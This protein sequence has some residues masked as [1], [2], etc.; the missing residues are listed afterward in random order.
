MLFLYFLVSRS[1]MPVSYHQELEVAIRSVRVAAHVCRAVQ[2][3]MVTPQSLEK[4]D[5][6]PVTVADFASQAIVC[7]LLGDVLP[8]DPVVGE[9][10]AAALRQDEQVHVRDAVAQHVCEVLGDD[11]LDTN[12]VLSWIDRGNADGSTGRYWTL[13]PIDGT[14][15]FLRKEQY[16]I[17]L[18]L[19]EHHEVVLGVLGCPNLSV[20]DQKGALYWAHEGVGAHAAPLWEGT[21]VPS[22][23]TVSDSTDTSS[24]RFCESV[25]SAHSDQSQS[26]QIAARLGITNEAVRLDSQAKYA[27]VARGEAD[28]YMRLPT[29]ADYRENIWDHAAGMAIIQ[30]AGGKVTDITGTQLDFSYGK[31]LEQNKGIIATNGKLHDQVIEAVSAVVDL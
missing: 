20:G 11:S 24:A 21:A 7:K 17:A 23:V 3:D 6:S 28:I 12:R 1:G 13:D 27:V 26:G 19:I 18:A 30:A 29:R 25:E 10:D 16:A 8:D 4:K 22:P 31:R 14:K 5:R 9:E 15:G 2:D